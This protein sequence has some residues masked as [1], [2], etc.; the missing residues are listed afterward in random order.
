MKNVVIVKF[1][2][3]IAIAVGLE[4]EADRLG[5]KTNAYI[6]LLLGQ[7]VRSLQKK[8]EKEL[9]LSGK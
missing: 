1:P 8:S 2:L 3:D 6:K 9:K 7:H 4:A 5:I